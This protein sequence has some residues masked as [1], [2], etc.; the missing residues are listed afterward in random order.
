MHIN[1]PAIRYGI[2]Y[3]RHFFMPSPIASHPATACVFNSRIVRLPPGQTVFG[4]QIPT[5]QTG[6]Q[7][8]SL[9]P[10]CY[11]S[12]L[13][14]AVSALFCLRSAIRVKQ[15]TIN[16]KRSKRGGISPHLFRPNEGVG[17]NAPA[18][19]ALACPSL[20]LEL[21]SDPAGKTPA[22]HAEKQ[23]T[24]FVLSFFFPGTVLGL[25]APWCR[26]C[27]LYTSPSPRD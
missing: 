1:V 10:P 15:Q 24:P 26:S 17:K 12:Q 21:H 9:P 14:V 16:G 8:R 3:D 19:G 2:Q 18:A 11:L 23:R 22:A 5:G 6:T 4:T 27:L 25:M 13:D 20:S 7:S